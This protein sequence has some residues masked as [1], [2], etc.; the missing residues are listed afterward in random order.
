MHKG[1]CLCGPV[2]F[3]FEVS[4]RAQSACER[5]PT[6]QCWPSFQTQLDGPLFVPVQDVHFSLKSTLGFWPLLASTLQ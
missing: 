2:R 5:C 4:E 6:Y 3:D 1:S